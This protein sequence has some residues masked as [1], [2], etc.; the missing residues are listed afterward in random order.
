MRAVLGAPIAI[1]KKALSEKNVFL[2][3]PLTPPLSNF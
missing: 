3:K 1:D 2:L